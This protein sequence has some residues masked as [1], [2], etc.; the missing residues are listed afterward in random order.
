[1]ASGG[2]GGGRCG[3]HSVAAGRRGFGTWGEACTERAQ[4]QLAEVTIVKIPDSHPHHRHHHHHHHHRLHERLFPPHRLHRH[5][6]LTMYPASHA[7]G[8]NSLG[9]RGPRGGRC[10]EYPDSTGKPL[11]IPEETVTRPASLWPRRAESGSP[12]AG[13]PPALAVSLAEGSSVDVLNRPD[14]GPNPTA[15]PR[16]P[17]VSG[18]H[19]YCVLFLQKS[20]RKGRERLPRTAQRHS[21]PQ[22]SG[23]LS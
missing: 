11:V 14:R 5:R 4:P 17:C 2:G 16:A 9:S 22:T 10:L 6:H 8:K 15:W 23:A 21:R 3:L 19:P 1:M 12:Q 20:N 13:L 18:M 7:Q